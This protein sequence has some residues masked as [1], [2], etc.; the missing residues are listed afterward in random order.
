MQPTTSDTAYL[1]GIEIIILRGQ[2]SDGLV[3]SGSASVR[4]GLEYLAQM[5][6]KLDRRHVVGVDKMMTVGQHSTLRQFHGVLVSLDEQIDHLGVVRCPAPFLGRP[7]L[8][9]VRIAHNPLA[10]AKTP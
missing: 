4:R 1:G 7:R 5:L 3:Q 10:M 6:P 9:Y 2:P 8:G